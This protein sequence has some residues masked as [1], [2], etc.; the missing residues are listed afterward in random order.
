MIHLIT[1]SKTLLLIQ[2]S[3]I[4]LI[5]SCNSSNT[6]E[7]ERS[8]TCVAQ[9]PVEEFH[10]D[11]DIAMTMRSIADAIRVGESLD[12]SIYNYKGILT[13]GVGRP[14]YTDIYGA[15]GEWEVN[16]T[17]KSS[18]KINNTH[19]GDLVVDDLEYYIVSNLD[20]TYNNLVDSLNTTHSDGSKVTVY[21][22]GEGYLKIDVHNSKT[23]TG[24]EG[25]MVCMTASKELPHN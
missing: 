8:D 2:L 7:S 5:F 14:I 18:V 23:S 11:N 24:I 9:T 22:L 10:A 4:I 13:D 21:D 16:V 3:C 15:P 6:H 20:L 12:S 17:S 25:A 19:I 1:N